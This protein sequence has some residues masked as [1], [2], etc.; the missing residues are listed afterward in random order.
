MPYLHTNIPL[1]ACLPFALP[2]K[3]FSVCRACV[4]C[5]TREKALSPISRYVDL[6]KYV[7]GTCCRSSQSIEAYPGTYLL[8]RE[9]EYVTVES[10]FA[11][12][13]DSTC[14][15]GRASCFV[16]YADRS[17]SQP[18]PTTSSRVSV[19][20]VVV[21]ASPPLAILLQITSCRN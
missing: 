6:T 18:K 9:S 21:V 19:V 4:C 12:G 15:C 11:C 3:W 7:Y 16:T 1:F 10:S 5:A 8:S 17:S 14:D 13:A 20:V 2:Q